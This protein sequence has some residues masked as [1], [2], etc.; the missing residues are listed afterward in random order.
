MGTP[1]ISAVSGLSRSYPHVAVIIYSSTLSG[2]QELLRLGA[3]GYIA[4][5]DWEDDVVMAI[6]SVMRGEVFLSTTV[7]EYLERSG[8]TQKEHQL[9]SKELEVLRLVAE[10][11]STQDIVAHLTIAEQTVRN[12]VYSLFRKTGCS[13][14]TQ[15]VEWYHR[16]AS[17]S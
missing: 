8:A 1:P 4:K 6:Q 2:A 14:R 9:T 7:N 11:Y 5:E 3:R 17:G 16:L 10:G 12:Y 15:L 13:G